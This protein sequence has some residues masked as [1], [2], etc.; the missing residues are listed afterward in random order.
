MVHFLRFLDW[1]PVHLGDK[2][3]IGI[4]HGHGIM[5]TVT[6][7]SDVGIVVAAV[8]PAGIV[9]NGIADVVAFDGP[10]GITAVIR[11]IACSRHP[12]NARKT[13]G[14]DLVDDGLEEIVQCLRIV[15]TISIPQVY[16]FIGQLDADL[17][18]IFADGVVLREDIPH[19]HQI[20]VV[21]VTHLDIM[22]TDAWRTD[23]HIHTVVHGFLGQWEIDRFQIGLQSVGIKLLDISLTRGI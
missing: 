20:L 21:V 10:G 13:V 19:R 2:D 23:Y 1:T 6:F 15:L 22:R 4:N 14:T 16:G 11:L 12:D 9:V 8:I 18:G 17:S 5:E 7:V 3:R